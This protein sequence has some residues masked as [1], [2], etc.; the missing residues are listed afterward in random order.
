MSSYAAWEKKEKSNLIFMFISFTFG[1]VGAGAS[2]LLFFLLYIGS[3]VSAGSGG[4]SE[5][6]HLGC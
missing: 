5:H 3:G 1:S 4:L 2:G 6:A